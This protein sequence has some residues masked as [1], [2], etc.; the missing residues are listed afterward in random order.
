MTN[1]LHHIQ[2]IIESEEMQKGLS[3]ARASM[4]IIS[5]WCAQSR[6]LGERL[7]SSEFLLMQDNTVSS[8]RP[9]PMPNHESRGLLKCHIKS[10][11]TKVRMYICRFI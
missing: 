1:F 5:R 2:K 7:S 3:V 11:S 8:Q 10:W 9:Y 4:P 6:F